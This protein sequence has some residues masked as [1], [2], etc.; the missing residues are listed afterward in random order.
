MRGVWTDADVGDEIDRRDDVQPGINDASVEEL[1]VPGIEAAGIYRIE[2]SI[3]KIRRLGVIKNL[4]EQPM[5]AGQR[6][7]AEPE[8]VVGPTAAPSPPSPDV[9]VSAEIVARGRLEMTPREVAAR[10]QTDPRV[11]GKA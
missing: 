8:I 9:G 11:V 4:L 10:H 7:R 6:K 5:F 2:Y 1:V 3:P